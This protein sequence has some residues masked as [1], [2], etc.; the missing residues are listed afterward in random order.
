[1]DLAC[2]DSR[3]K[4]REEV[5]RLTRKEKKK[6][7]T[8]DLGE[9]RCTEIELV[10]CLS[11]TNHHIQSFLIPFLCL[12]VGRWTSA[13]MFSEA[14]GLFSLP[15]ILYFDS[16]LN[17]NL[18]FT[19]LFFDANNESYNEKMNHLLLSTVH[20]VA[21]N[22]I[23]NNNMQSTV[24]VRCGSKFQIE[25]SK[26]LARKLLVKSLNFDYR[27][28]C[29]TN[30]SSPPTNEKLDYRSG[31]FMS[32]TYQ[33]YLWKIRNLMKFK[34]WSELETKPGQAHLMTDVNCEGFKDD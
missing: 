30:F 15:R 27:Q 5:N 18:T 7:K 13:K 19:R 33:L 9:A 34:I 2:P 11:F 1:M 24:N 8:I 21:L 22:W 26:K 28:D 10:W 14:T 20:N 16:S 17:I 6:K 12:S 29:R 3:I 32:T 31:V 25:I 23:Y 4:N